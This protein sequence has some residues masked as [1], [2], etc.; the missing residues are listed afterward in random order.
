MENAEIWVW[1]VDASGLY[2]YSSPV[3]TKLLGYTPDE[4][5]G[6]MHFYDLF[7]PQGQAELTAAALAAF[8][9]A[10]PFRD[11]QNPNRH[12]SG[13]DVILE[14]NGI[15]ILDTN[16]TLQGYRGSDK[17]VTARVR[18]EQLLRESEI[19]HR[20]LI[21]HI[22][23][24]VYIFSSTRGGIYY[25]PQVTSI[26]GYTPEQLY[27]QPTLWHDSIHPENVPTVE[28]NIQDAFHGAGFCF[29]YRIRDAHGAWHWFDDRSIE[30]VVDG[31]RSH[32]QRV[33]LRH[34]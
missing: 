13:Y 19:H 15:P 9:S 24:I 7:A 26:L 31:P 21:E 27:A 22:P 29:E 23:G 25:S 32:L 28:K 34:H 20:S 2:T 11:F 12:K 4:L 5:V 10:Q 1:E 17:D 8:R 33:R 30:C 3:V 16:G 14:T 18:A 6:K